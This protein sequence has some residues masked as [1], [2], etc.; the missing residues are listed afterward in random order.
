MRGKQFLFSKF[1]KEKTFSMPRVRNSTRWTV[2]SSFLLVSLVFC[3]CTRSGDL[4]VEEATI[5]LILAATEAENWRII[6]LPRSLVNLW[7]RFVN[8]ASSC[9]GEERRVVNWCSYR[10]G[11]VPRMPRELV[12]IP[13]KN[14]IRV[15]SRERRL[16]RSV[17]RTRSHSCVSVENSPTGPVNQFKMSNLLLSALMKGRNLTFAEYQKTLLFRSRK[18]KARIFFI[19][20]FRVHLL[21]R[22]RFALQ[23]NQIWKLFSA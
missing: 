8:T 13:R 16:S 20:I 4:W 18:W 1:S 2:S 12:D 23:F 17:H 6:A 7:S 22:F 15:F 19:S 3:I 14:W 10:I 9:E 21:K 11:F 5:L